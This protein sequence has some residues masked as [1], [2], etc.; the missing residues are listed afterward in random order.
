MTM[1]LTSLEE[2]T[3]YNIACFIYCLKFKFVSPGDVSDEAGSAGDVNK[4]SWVK[5][6]L[7]QSQA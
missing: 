2:I 7:P 5:E 3:L 6:I 1:L 4:S